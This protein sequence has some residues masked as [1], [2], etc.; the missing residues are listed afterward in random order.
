MVGQFRAVVDGFRPDCPSD[1]WDDVL[2]RYSVLVEKGPQ[3][4][5]LIAKK[6]VNGKGIWELLGHGGN[7]QPRLLFYFIEDRSTDRVRP[8]LH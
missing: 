1:A 5:P 8:R 6:L 3:C 4:G 2:L 7:I